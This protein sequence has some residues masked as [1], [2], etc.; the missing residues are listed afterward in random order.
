MSKLSRRE[1]FA[2]ALVPFAVGKPALQALL[3]RP[4]AESATHASDPTPP[5]E[6]P[7]PEEEGCPECG[8]WGRMI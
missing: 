8:G 3:I 7:F 1:L 4:L 5:E 2:S 6:E